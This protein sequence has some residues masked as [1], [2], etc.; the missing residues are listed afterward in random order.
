METNLPTKKILGVIVVL[1]VVVLTAYFYLFSTIKS[2]NESTSVLE[3]VLGSQISRESELKLV[4]TS[5]RETEKERALINSY[6]VQEGKGEVAGFVEFVESIAKSA[7]VSL[8]VSS[9]L[10]KKQEDFS[11]TEKMNLGLEVE[12]SWTD[13][14]YFLEL[15]ELLPYKVSFDRS[16]IEKI[17]DSSLWGSTFN[18]S[19]LKLY[20]I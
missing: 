14:I 9:I 18:I 19:V 4:G 17:E 16:Y 20:Q 2:K 15:L 6:F 10:L 1:N 7:G 12:G 8:S 13:T 11:I 3:N 5:L